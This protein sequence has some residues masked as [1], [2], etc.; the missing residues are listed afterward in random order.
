MTIEKASKIC[1]NKTMAINIYWIY[2]QQIA[3][4]AAFFGSLFV[5]QKKKEMSILNFVDKTLTFR[6]NRPE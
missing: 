5:A 2:S 3:Y 4:A 1:G 6:L